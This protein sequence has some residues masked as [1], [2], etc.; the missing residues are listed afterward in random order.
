MRWDF[1][2]LG[3]DVIGIYAGVIDTGMIDNLEVEKSTPEA[4]VENALSGIKAGKLD[5]ATDDSSTSRCLQFQSHLNETL[6]ERSERAD[7]FRTNY[8]AGGKDKAQNP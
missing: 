2:K 4:T 8:P 1:Q 3:V 7:L 5:I 6:E